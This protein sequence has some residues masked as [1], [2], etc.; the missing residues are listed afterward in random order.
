METLKCL[1]S[2]EDEDKAP[3]YVM[4]LTTFT[5]DGKATQWNEWNK[6]DDPSQLWFL[7]S[8]VKLNRGGPY[9]QW[10][11]IEGL[12]L[13]PASLKC[14]SALSRR[15]R[16]FTR[17][18]S[19][20][21]SYVAFGPPR[22]SEPRCF[23]MRTTN[24]KGTWDYRWAGLSEGCE[25]AVQRY[26]RGGEKGARTE[27]RLRAVEFGFDGSWIVY[28][29]KVNDEKTY[30]GKRHYYDWWL[31]RPHYSEKLE[32]ALLEGRENGW[33]IN[34]SV[35]RLAVY[36]RQSLTRR[37]KKVSLNLRNPNEYVLA[38][39]D[40]ARLYAALH[41]NY[42]EKFKK[43]AAEW[44][45][46]LPLSNKAIAV[47]TPLSDAECEH[48]SLPPKANDTSSAPQTTSLSPTGHEL[49]APNVLGC[50]RRGPTLRNS[51]NAPQ[52]QGTSLQADMVELEGELPPHFHPPPTDEDTCSLCK[53]GW[54]DTPFQK[55]SDSVD[56][57]KVNTE[58]LERRRGFKIFG[59]LITRASDPY[60][61]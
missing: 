3:R 49:P 46:G 35:W 41:V 27:G 58:E 32:N 18:D 22:G 26:M 55:K 61:T 56:L 5:P 10:N 38:F 16:D 15:I 37:Q 34:V 48:V 40:D 7:Y 51:P 29:S 43:V 59:Y 45:D 14:H 11:S 6:Q 57:V 13:P 47:Y 36:L 23:F 33:S 25:M 17:K 31:S 42:L 50:I 21:L 44:A 1:E 12:E 53:A 30:G 20:K 60:V 4:N 54:P 19:N 52:Q 8:W 2:D 39:N 28:G 9:C 24:V